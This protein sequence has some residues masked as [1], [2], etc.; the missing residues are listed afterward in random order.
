[1][2]L[3]RHLGAQMRMFEHLVRGDGDG[4]AAH[5]RFYD[6]YMSVMDLPA[7]YYLQTVKTV[8][9][10]HA[11]AK[12]T[13]VSRGRKIDPGAIAKT[14][15]MTI[16]GEHDDISGLGQTRAAHALCSGLPE[17]KHRHYVQEGVGHYGIFNGRR[18]RDRIM[19]LVA[20]FIAAFNA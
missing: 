1:M 7:E 16:E 17:E 4:A 5:R 20:D 14:A 6:E 18:W 9:Q 11:L 8:F 15:L 12:G 3:E 2:N 10:D 19:P 13:M